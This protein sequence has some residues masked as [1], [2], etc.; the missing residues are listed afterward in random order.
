[1]SAPGRD[2]RAGPFA[3]T[4]DMTTGRAAYRRRVPVG[5][6]RGATAVITA[7]VAVALFAA[8][9]LAV[10]LGNV[11]TR[12]ARV[13]AVADQAALAAAAALPDPCAAVR[14]A[15][16]LLVED[17]N[18]VL[19]DI[20]EEDVST[21]EHMAEHLTDGD[22]ANGT[23]R[24]Y[25]PTDSYDPTDEDAGF[26]V[27]FGPSGQPVDPGDCAQPATRARLVGPSAT[28]AVGLAAA[29]GVDP[30]D[31]AAAAGA[32][33]VAPL[34]VMPFAVAEECSAVGPRTYVVAPAEPVVLPTPDAPAS[35]TPD[36]VPPQVI[37]VTYRPGLDGDQLVADLTLFPPTFDAARTGL[38]VAEYR[39]VR[40]G[41]LL[42]V[43][44]AFQPGQPGVLLGDPLDAELRLR[45]PTEVL[46]AGGAWRVRV[47]RVALA[48]DSPVAPFTDAI[49]LTRPV[50]WATASAVLTI[51]EPAAPPSACDT[52]GTYGDVLL[53]D[54]ATPRG[55]SPRGTVATGAT[56]AVPIGTDVVVAGAAQ[57]RAWAAD[58]SSGVLSR[59]S[60]PGPACPA[61]PP[62]DRPDWTVAARTITATN[63]AGCYGS[64]V[65][66]APDLAWQFTDPRLIEDPRFFLVPVVDLDSAVPD[67][68]FPESPV[69]VPVTGYRLA[70]VTDE[71]PGQSLPTCDALTCTGITVA[72]PTGP[73]ARLRVHVMEP[74]LDGLTGRIRLRDNGHP[75]LTGPLPST[76][77][78]DVHLIE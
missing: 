63:G 33:L 25:G 40:D 2:T 58:V 15:A 8:G 26:D 53:L 19:D 42:Q 60:T 50:A 39:S 44:G 46:E 23:I 12:Q 68:R 77:P 78:R 55:S 4:D 56:R 37:G 1:L 14:A 30:I 16:E 70:F 41:T 7:V 48:G 22:P 43:P 45:V 11:Y 54:E 76:A 75:W 20:A 51:S 9:A 38:W 62:L 21:W 27:P 31:V 32:A 3:V 35:F 71:T 36:G 57:Q 5:D 17:G 65:G 13:E 24:F 49:G 34:P 52:A 66:S 72:S 61:G 47:G 67:L 28:V 64:V 10:D 69:T 73:V 29:V 74:G 18:A 6:D 59:L